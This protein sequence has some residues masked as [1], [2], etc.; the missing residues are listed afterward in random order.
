M[1]ERIGHH[2]RPSCQPFDARQVLEGVSH[3]VA[4]I[5]VIAEDIVAGEPVT[6]VMRDRLFTAAGRLSTA[7][8]ASPVLPDP[9]ELKVIRSGQGAS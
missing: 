8:L 1:P 4:V 3:E 7:L 6:E 2:Y 9:K 5:A